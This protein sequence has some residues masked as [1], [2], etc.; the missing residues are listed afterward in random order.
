V[1]K[2]TKFGVGHFLRQKEAF[3]ASE[4]PS[5]QESEKPDSQALHAI[6]TISSDEK[7]GYGP[8]RR[9][10]Y[11]KRTIALSLDLDEF[12]EHA[13]RQHVRPNGEPSTVYAH[14]VE[15]LIAAERNRRAM[16]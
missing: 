14:F 4:N 3:S 11:R 2:D 12:V 1:A 15:D 7:P 6:A 5:I 9:G 8:R 16:Q 13:R 10:A